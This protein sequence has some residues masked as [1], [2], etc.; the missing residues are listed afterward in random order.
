MTPRLVVGI[1]LVLV[2]AVWIGQ[3]VGAI[4]GS[5]MTGNA[6]WA[7]IGAVAVFFGLSLVA[8]ARRDRGG[9]RD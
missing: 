5:F 7:V 9:P 8:G 3:G 4:G 2:G 1:V 6:I